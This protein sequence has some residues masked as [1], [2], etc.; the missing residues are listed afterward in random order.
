MFQTNQELNREFARLEDLFRD[1]A[2]VTAQYRTEAEQLADQQARLDA[3]L[4]AGAIDA[5]TY[6]RAIDD[7]GSGFDGLGQSMSSVIKTLVTDWRR[8][9]DVAVREIARIVEA[10]ARARVFDPA[11][12]A[13]G[14]LFDDL[15]DDLFNGSGGGTRPT[16]STRIFDGTGFLHGGGVVGRDRVMTRPMPAALFAGAP[17]LHGGLGP[18]E[19]PAI[20]QRGEGVFTPGQMRALGGARELSI[21][22]RVINETGQPIGVEASR[23]ADGGIDMRVLSGEVTAQ[24]L[25]QPESRQI[26]RQ[27][28]GLGQVLRDR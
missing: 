17:R 24:G 22:I 14:G 25:T 12:E 8:L 11:G 26:L 18:G 20:L 21:E 19:Y 3:L 23:G 13:V 6:R 28:Y 4:S 15:I 5:E 1:G 10:Q 2:R 27:V 9:G 16:P 7:L